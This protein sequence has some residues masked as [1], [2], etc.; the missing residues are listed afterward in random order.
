MCRAV[1]VCLKGFYAG[2]IY[3]CSILIYMFL[4][5]AWWSGQ[6]AVSQICL[7]LSN[8][9]FKITKI[10][11]CNNTIFFEYFFWYS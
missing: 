8:L 6:V 4:E 2:S 1:I 3:I 10:N 7:T 5:A 9:N 11:T